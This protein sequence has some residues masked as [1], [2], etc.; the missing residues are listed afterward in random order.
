M[1]TF[2]GIN[3]A[4]RALQAA[5]RQM[6]VAGQNLANADT[7][8]YSR[9]R[10]ELTPLANGAGSTYGR[11]DG[12]GNGVEIRGIT[13]IA[14]ALADSAQRH[15][16]AVL[17]E[18]QLTSSVYGEIEDSLGEPSA[19]G[20]TAQLNT[21][22]KAFNDLTNASGPDGVAAARTNVLRTAD[23]VADTL[24]ATERRL[25]GQFESLRDQTGEMAAGANEQ[26]QRIATLNEEIRKIVSTG[27]N[28]NELMDQ[29]DTH[30]R[31]LAEITGARVVQRENGMSDVYVGNSP[32]VAGT[33]AYK[34]EVV[35]PRLD[36]SQAQGGMQLALRIGGNATIPEGGRLKGAVDAVS[37]V[38]P[39]VANQ[40][41][42]TAATL[43]KQVNDI[44][45]PGG[46]GQD[47]FTTTTIAA[48]SNIGAAGT[49]R[50]AVPDAASLRDSSGGTVDRARAKALAQLGTAPG[51]PSQVWQA[52]VTS[53]GTAAQASGQRA[54]LAEQVSLKSTAAR[55]AVSGVNIDEEMTNLVAFQHAYGAAARVLTT[56]DQALDT[57][58][59]RTGLVGR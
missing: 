2:S 56:I 11:K 59:N 46:T 58:I 45:N 8:G 51:G 34:L 32:I 30:I 14:D 42:A 53:I 55:E 27:A 4:S 12:V 15:D 6:E 43:A 47:F 28:A 31:Q 36:F 57:L 5:Q 24:N 10:V 1:S 23:V 17:A 18:H 16:A 50:V 26:A 9:Q 48:G 3:S 7:E 13:R 37:K 54:V 19:A 52:N 35:N 41:D 20:L 39:G 40:L 44:Y 33:T 22:Y 38:I 29:R 49:I 25:K 21:M